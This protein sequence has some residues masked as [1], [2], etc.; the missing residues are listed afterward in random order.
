MNKSQTTTF[1]EWL[2]ETAIE[3]PMLQRDYAQG[4]TD[5]KTTALRKRFV[6]DLLDAA[7]G[8]EKLHLD[9]IYGPEHDGTFQPLDGQQRLTTLFLLHWYLAVKASKLSEVKETLAKFRYKVRVSTQEFITALLVPDNVQK[10]ELSKKNLK[11]AK[12]YF[13]SWDYDPSIQGMLNMIDTIHEK[14]KDSSV[15]ELSELW[16]SLTSL[17]CPITFTVLNMEKFNLADELY[18]KMNARG[19]P[20]TDFENFKAWLHRQ[21]EDQ[22]SR[23]KYF[24]KSQD[25]S[26]INIEHWGYKLDREWSEFFW[27]KS[28][29][30]NKEE[31]DK[32]VEYDPKVMNDTFLRFFQ[33]ATLNAYAVRYNGGD[34]EGESVE[35]KLCRDNISRL[36]DSKDYISNEE[37]QKTYKL[38]CGETL[39]ELFMLFDFLSEDAEDKWLKKTLEPVPFFFKERDTPI[40]LLYKGKLTYPQRVLFHALQQF[41]VRD[42]FQKKPKEALIAWMRVIRNLVLNSTINAP[43]PFVR[44][45]K[46][47]DDLLQK[48]GTK[49]CWLKHIAEETN[50]IEG[51][52]TDQIAEERLKAKL[53]IGDNGTDW[54]RVIVGAENHLFFKGRI[55]VFLDFAE[56]DLEAFS[57]YCSI[58]KKVFT[59]EETT[60]KFKLK[61]ETALQCT[62]LSIGDYLLDVE[63]R[64][65]SIC[66][67]RDEWMR[68]FKTD[69]KK[70]LKSLFN[71]IDL[72]IIDE[73][74]TESLMSAISKRTLEINDIPTWRRLLIE[75][76]NCINE[77]L[78]GRL[79]FEDESTN[80]QDYD[81]IRLLKTSARSGGQAELRTAYIFHKFVKGQENQ[82]A[83]F[84][85]EHIF[86]YR[87]SG[88]TSS[89]C[90]AFKHWKMKKGKHQY[91]LDVCYEKSNSFRFKFFNQAETEPE[92]EIV[93]LLKELFFDKDERKFFKIVLCEELEDVIG[94]IKS[95]CSSLNDL[96]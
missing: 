31:P 27:K 23:G 13:S 14:L 58:G 69:K 91:T 46:S 76:P 38:L 20:L 70:Y 21:C 80:D 59:V 90:I 72:S 77:C 56:V 47:V 92:K 18:M 86:Y 88:S 89:P 44:A 25:V 6:S 61:H 42:G 43:A 40:D 63:S 34:I 26:K 84:N 94:K 49:Q 51:F 95:I 96:S 41:V 45:I 1:Y 74:K 29:K 54:E 8:K 30:E 52:S 2:N 39:E 82:F 15:D 48:A 33:L 19:L 35:A 37:Y 22:A 87:P 64:R 93:T 57:K 16:C 75:E 53:M 28:K 5:P 60:H 79:S 4:R 81:N 71:E 9:F 12:W 11:D 10:E 7:G 50:K 3:I 65:Y 73:V 36:A 55:H 17:C 24:S 62:L 66:K 85:K 32:K 83:P 67:D 68:Y 78:E